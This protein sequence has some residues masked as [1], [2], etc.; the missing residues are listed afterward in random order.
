M[1][2]DDEVHAVH[3]CTPNYLH[4]EIHEKTIKAG[5]P[6]FSEKP[7]CKT[8]KESE[9]LLRLL[10]EYPETVAGVDFVYRMNPLVL[11]MR[12]KILAG[13]LEKLVNQGLFMALI[14]RTG[15][16][17]RRIITGEWI[18]GLAAREQ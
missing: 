15:C 6:I 3:N 17:M 4:K 8:A 11:D 10:E 5:K 9:G 16:C 18:P 7:L 12:E 13:T 1:L 14:S 2:A